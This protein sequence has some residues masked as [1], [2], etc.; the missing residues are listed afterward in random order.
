M[1]ISDRLR[2]AYASAPAEVVLHTTIEFVGYDLRFVQSFEDL[3]LGGNVYEAVAMSVEM[4]DKSTG[5]NQTLS[6]SFG[7]V[8]SRAQSIIDSAMNSGSPMVV[9]CS[10]WISSDTS[11]PSSSPIKMQVIGGA[12]DDMRAVLQIECSFFDM[13]NVKWPREIYTAENAPGMKWQ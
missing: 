4:P 9:I 13:L 3:T 8:D 2:V 5:G 7:G 12:F 11:A 10:S 6:I 1:A